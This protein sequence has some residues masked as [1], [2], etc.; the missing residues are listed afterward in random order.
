[1]SLFKKKQM[2]KISEYTSQ[3]YSEMYLY[4]YLTISQSMIT[5]L[6]DSYSVISRSQD[7]NLNLTCAFIHCFVMT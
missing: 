4:L 7:N 3:V 1:M 6:R 2:L 5:F